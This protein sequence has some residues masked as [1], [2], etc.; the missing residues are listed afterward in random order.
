MPSFWHSSATWSATLPW[1]PP[2]SP[3]RA[4]GRPRGPAPAHTRAS[5]EA[6]VSHVEYD[7]FLPSAAFSLSPSFALASKRLG[8]AGHATWLQFESGNSSIQGLV[9]G[10]LFLPGSAGPVAGRA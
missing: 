8:F 10:S 3:R 7:G 9:A 5:L 4:A 2:R 6:G 1:V